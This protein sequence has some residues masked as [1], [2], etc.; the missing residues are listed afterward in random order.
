MAPTSCSWSIF[1]FDSF[2]FTCVCVG[3]QKVSQRTIYARNHT[4]S[5]PKRTNACT[6]TQLSSS[7]VLTVGDRLPG[8]ICACKHACVHVHE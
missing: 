8:V 4:C 2:R 5:N 7:S 1:R 3:L 6:A